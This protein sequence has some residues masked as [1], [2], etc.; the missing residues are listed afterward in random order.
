MSAT[1]S[2]LLI[3]TDSSAQIGTGHARRC[4]ALA[5]AWQT[6]GGKALLAAAELTGSIEER[7]RNEGCEVFRITA[8]A[9]SSA[10]ARQAAK[11][12]LGGNATWVV[13]DGYQFEPLYI[14]EVKRAGLRV[15]AIDDDAR[16]E[17]Y[18]SDVVLNQN[19]CANEAQYPRRETYT[20]LLLGPEFVLLRPEFLAASRRREFSGGVRNILLTMGGSDPENVTM[21]VMDALPELGADIET[22]IV[23]GAANR[24]YEKLCERG[25]HLPARFRFE[26]DPADMPGLMRSA[27]LAI[28]AAGSTCWE[29]AFMGVPALLMV[30]AKNQEAIANALDE[31]GIAINLGW[32]AELSAK[33]IADSVLQVQ[34]DK[35]R[36]RDMSRR[37]QDLIDGKGAARVVQHLQNIL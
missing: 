10:D 20:R 26:R 5:K 3:R 24:H 33:R 11:L 31:R 7:F 1:S 32:H 25:K 13:V 21:K 34:Q 37:G 6:T 12:A 16:F 14:Q 18:C 17:H 27:D 36:L 35:E 28:S 15:M 2:T 9:G 8:V 29:L 22:A 19:V 23:V 30:L 4:L